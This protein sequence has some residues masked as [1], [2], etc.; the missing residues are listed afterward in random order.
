MP[1]Q[2]VVF[3]RN[4]SEA[5]SDFAINIELP[6]WMGCVKLQPNFINGALPGPI[7]IR[8]IDILSDGS[9]GAVI[10]AYFDATLSSTAYAASLSLTPESGKVPLTGV[11][12]SFVGCKFVAV[13]AETIKLTD[14]SGFELC[15]P[16]TKSCDEVCG[17]GTACATTA[18]DI[19]AARDLA[20]P[21]LFNLSEEFAPAPATWSWASDGGTFDDAT[22][23]TP[24]LTI[25]NPTIDGTEFKLDVTVTYPNGS[26]FTLTKTLV[27]RNA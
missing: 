2:E 27:Y 13:F 19:V 3:S 9:E 6:L 1:S 24:A 7:L 12:D 17:R 20:D 26:Q 22:I 10:E 21:F 18:P 8:F 11:V 23:A 25:P 5:V 4:G 15:H 14:T 16:I